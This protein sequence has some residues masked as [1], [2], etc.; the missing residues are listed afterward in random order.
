MDS[1]FAPAAIFGDPAV[2]RAL[3]YTLHPAQNT[4]TATISVTKASMWDQSIHA[5]TIIAFVF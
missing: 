5:Q 4:A 1:A 3:F 2:F